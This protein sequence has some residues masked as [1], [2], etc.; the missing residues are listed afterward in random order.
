MTRTR[1]RYPPSMSNV[2]SEQ[3]KQQVIALGRLGWSLRRIQRATV[4][5]VAH[6][7]SNCSQKCFPIPHCR[8]PTRGSGRNHQRQI[9]HGLFRA[10][11]IVMIHRRHHV[12]TRRLGSGHDAWVT[13]GE[14]GWVSFGERRSGILDFWKSEGDDDKQI[15]I[16]AFRFS[17]GVRW[18]ESST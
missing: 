7:S 15:R 2:L 6:N 10:S 3:N 13:F 11:G 9:L 16:T 1:G 8:T 5:R 12:E 14:Y 17:Q 4:R 18:G